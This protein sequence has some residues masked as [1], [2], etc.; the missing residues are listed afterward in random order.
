MKS[1]GGRRGGSINSQLRKV[2]GG[3]ESGAQ[4]TVNLGRICKHFA[5]I[6]SDSVDPGGHRSTVNLG[7][8]REE[9]AMITSYSVDPRRGVN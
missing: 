2:V 9:F 4:S 3:E 7:M 8:I 5:R 1:V 6:T